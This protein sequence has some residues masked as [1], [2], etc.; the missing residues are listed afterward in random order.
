MDTYH[1]VNDV[2]SYAGPRPFDWMHTE[3]AQAFLGASG[4]SFGTYVL[5]LDV[6]CMHVMMPEDN[7]HLGKQICIVPTLSARTLSSKC[8]ISALG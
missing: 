5:P 3:T 6:V 8:W 1:R 4:H 7:S 2:P